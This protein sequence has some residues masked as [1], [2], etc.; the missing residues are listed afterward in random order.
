[1]Q[2]RKGFDPTD[3]TNWP[4]EW[5]NRIGA[6]ALKFKAAQDVELLE[7]ENAVIATIS[8]EAADHDGEIVRQRGL[9]ISTFKKNPVILFGHDPTT[10][11][12]G[13]AVWVKKMKAADGTPITRAKIQFSKT[14]PMAMQVMDLFKEGIL[15]AFSIGFTVQEI[16]EIDD[17]DSMAAFEITRSTLLE[18]SVVPIPANP[19]A[20]VEAV[21]K[22]RVTHPVLL[23]QYDEI[24]DEADAAPVSAQ[25]VM[26][27]AEWT[28]S[29]GKMSVITDGSFFEAGTLQS[30]ERIHAGRKYTLVTGMTPSGGWHIHALE[31]DATW[32]DADAKAF[33]DKRGAVAFFSPQTEAIK[34]Q[35]SG[36]TDGAV[37]G[38][39]AVDQEALVEKIKTLIDDRIDAARG[40]V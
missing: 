35:K 31:Y 12:I 6:D 7:G 14:N 5:Q 39:M 13:K 3:V 9:D 18:T 32:S 16:R 22:G 19:Q 20:L 25:P 8:T 2:Y 29:G 26:I 11:P 15:K 28:P 30:F 24:Q 27:G 17:E 40:R 33:G 4:D 10:L 36:C 23:D 37:A 1:M 21:S 38:N 34:R